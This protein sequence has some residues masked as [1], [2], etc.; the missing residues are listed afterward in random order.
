MSGKPLSPAIAQALAAAEDYMRN[1]HALYR[2]L[3]MET[4]SVGR[5]EIEVSVTIPE[6]FADG[7][8]LH[9]G[10]FTT[11]LDTILAVSAWTQMEQFEPLATI[12]LKTD[13]FH[14]APPGVVVTCTAQCEG[15]LEE[16]AVC[17]GRAILPSGQTI[18]HAAGTFMV[19]TT[20][21][22]KGSRL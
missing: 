16:V 14:P 3:P 10:I 11:L 13:F 7:P 21:A 8:S 17:H 4:T 9:G 22:T 18:A 19:G 20:M 1:E 6:A 5:G 15:I 12:N 2:N